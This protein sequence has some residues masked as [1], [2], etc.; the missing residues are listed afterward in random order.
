MMMLI[1]RAISNI[2]INYK[3]HSKKDP[4]EKNREVDGILSNSLGPRCTSG[5]DEERGGHQ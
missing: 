3:S 1:A 4:S 2:L 5:M